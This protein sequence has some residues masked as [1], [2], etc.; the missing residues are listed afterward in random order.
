[1]SRGFGSKHLLNTCQLPEIHGN[2]EF[3][4]GSR[5]VNGI[6]SFRSDA[7]RRLAQCHGVRRGRFGLPLKEAGFRFKHRLLDLYETLLELLGEDP[8]WDVC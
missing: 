5:H 4:K 7:R 6:E 3:V 8:L 2:D 1:M